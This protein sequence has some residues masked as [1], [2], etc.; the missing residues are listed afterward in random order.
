MSKSHF[1]SYWDIIVSKPLKPLCVF[2]GGG[3]GG[4]WGGAVKKKTHKNFAIWFLMRCHM[5]AHSSTLSFL[6]Q[7]FVNWLPQEF[8]VLANKGLL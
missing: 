5:H 6:R 2:D 7:T 8:K 4:G 1:H 3:G